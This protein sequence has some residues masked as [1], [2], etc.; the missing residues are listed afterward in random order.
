MDTG[1]GGGIV[2]GGGSAVVGDVIEAGRAGKE[3]VV[4]GASLGGG[5]LVVISRGM[6]ELAGADGRRRGST[7]SAG[8]VF[9]T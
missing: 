8:R 9:D 3:G 1:I 6:P 7:G 2:A 4:N 5:W